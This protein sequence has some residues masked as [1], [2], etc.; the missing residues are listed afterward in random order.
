MIQ[1]AYVEATCVINGVGLIK[2]MGR[3]SGYIALNASLTQGGTDFCLIPENPYELPNLR[4]QTVSTN[5]FMTKLNNKVML[6]LSS[7][8][9]LKMA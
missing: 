5:R 3:H 6:S 8:K 2:L 7:P 9:E 4:D 1:A